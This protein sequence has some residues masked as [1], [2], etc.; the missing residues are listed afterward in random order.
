MTVT[1][2]KISG[3]TS[4]N[5]QGCGIYSYKDGSLTLSGEVEVTGNSKV[6]IGEYG[7][8]ITAFTNIKIQ[9]KIIVRDNTVVG[10]SERQNVV[11]RNG[12]KFIFTGAL[13]D[14]SNIGVKIIGDDTVITSG[15]SAY[16]D[17]RSPDT[18]FF[19][20]KRY[21]AFALNSSGE[22]EI[23]SGANYYYEHAYD[24]TNQKV[25]CTE[26]TILDY[27]VLTSGNTTL[28][29]GWY[30]VSGTVNFSDRI[31]VTGD[32][33]L[34]LTD[35][36]Q[37]GAPSGIHVSEY[38]KLTIY[39]GPLGTGELIAIGKNNDAAIG[40]YYNT[41]QANS[42]YDH[43]AGDVVIHGGKITATANYGAAIGCEHDAYTN[44][45]C[46]TMKNIII[47]GGQVTATSLK[48]CAL[49]G[50]NETS[51]GDERQITIYGGTL[52]AQGATHA[53]NSYTC[54]ISQYVY[55]NGHVEIAP[56]VKVSTGDDASSPTLQTSER[57]AACLAKYA[58]LTTCE[59]DSLKTT[60]TE[61]EHIYECPTCLYLIQ[62]A[63]SFS[64][65]T[66]LCSV[67]GYYDPQYI[68][69]VT[70]YTPRNNASGYTTAQTE[71]H[72][73][74]V[75]ELPV[76]DKIEG[77][78]FIGWQQVSSEDE[79]PTDT[80]APILGT[81]LP[82]GSH[83]TVTEDVSFVARYLRT[84]PYA[85]YDDATSIMTFYDD[86]DMTSRLSTTTTLFG[87]NSGN[88]IP[89]WNTGVYNDSIRKI[90]FDPSMAS[91]SVTSMAEWFALD[92]LES[93]EGLEYL[94]TSEVTTMSGLFY[95]NEK[96]T[97]IDVSTFDM[98][99]VTEVTHMFS[100]WGKAKKILI[101]LPK[102]TTEGYFSRSSSDQFKYSF[103]IV[104][105]TD[106]VNYTCKHFR[107]FDG[108]NFVVP[109]PFTATQT[110]F[111]RGFTKGRRSTVYLPYAFDTRAF[112]K[113]YSFSGELMPE[114]EGIRF[115]LM[116]VG[117]TVASIPYIIDPKGTTITSENVEVMAT[118]ET[119][120]TETN[121]MVGVYSRGY[122]PLNAY[123]YDASDGK[124]KRVAAE[125][126]VTIKAGR[127][128]FHIGDA[129]AANADVINAIFDDEVTGIEKTV[130]DDW[131]NDSDSAFYNLD[132]QKI[133]GKPTRKGIYILNGKKVVIN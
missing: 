50:D 88:Q 55:R 114:N 12:G 92:S 96:M 7:G 106:G 25:T 63:H 125:N 43:N 113:V 40:G 99:K 2:C 76:P 11:L 20:D 10:M 16:N 131:L 3:N 77:L 18:F 32:A 67:C 87:M 1:N 97:Y 120:I 27:N 69:D 48:G 84:G 9:G 61:T 72:D 26:K 82:A 59:H 85:L 107:L 28:G 31:H 94:N 4:G 37:M 34:L 123:C 129:V 58:L 21:Y 23:K 122:V 101:Y 44:N 95:G 33:K 6:G 127:A 42:Y 41:E 14:G 36:A 8:G 90:V 57:A 62:E 89:G 52:T 98:S 35:G 103:N 15:Y 65:K 51:W 130:A 111:D 60:L 75:F 83:I 105:T 66:H 49:G 29:D 73:K 13:Q 24:E 64:A 30:V 17:G 38:G 108:Y 124:L 68:F 119:T 5:G 54:E 93:I 91:A 19:S 132:G 46:P 115:D 110:T 70:C 109:K 100:L 47:W 128:Y 39:G 116:P 74:D 22:A 86:E 78:E 121:Q 133:N 80:Q 56:C 45:M 102:G 118:Q 71:V 79:L 117:K 112:G 104:E 53:I 81:L 126:A